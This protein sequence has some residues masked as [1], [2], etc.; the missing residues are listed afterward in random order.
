MSSAR[1]KAVIPVIVR[2]E[3]GARIATQKTSI[4]LDANG[5]LQFVLAD[6]ANGFPETATYS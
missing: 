1:W 5:H 4:S 3:N 6:L 2:D